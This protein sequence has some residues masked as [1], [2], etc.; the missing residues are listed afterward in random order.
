METRR[1]TWM[2][3]ARAFAILAVV[4][5]H[6]VEFAFPF[7]L[8]MWNEGTRLSWIVRLTLL[9]VGRL[10]V[11]LFLS[12]TGA[13]LLN[14]DY[15][16]EKEISRFYRQRFLRLLMCVE[17]WVLLYAFFLSWYHDLPFDFRR[18]MSSLVTT[19]QVQ[20][21]HMWYTPMILGMY[22]TIPFVARAL[23]GLSAKALLP[24][25]LVA[26]VVFSALP[27]VNLVLDVLGIV[28]REMLLDLSF[29]GG[30]Y[31]LYLIGG[32]LIHSRRALEKIPTPAVVVGVLGCFLGTAG[33]QVWRYAMGW[34]YK[35]WYDFAG[36]MA[37]GLLLFECFRRTQNSRAL[38]GISLYLSQ[39]SFA[40]YFLHFPIQCAVHAWGW[41]ELAGG[42]Y[43]QMLFLWVVPL[44]ASLALI[45]LLRPVKPIRRVLLYMN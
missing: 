34:D 33:F 16:D 8:E 27:S 18:L 19:S 9:S 13:L 11:P 17:C 28:N 3:R 29:S 15:T 39:R 22:L 7:R 6:A 37:A 38:E 14:R 5:C 40:I 10:G 21:G 30:V 4:L 45:E 1:N 25:L 41:H 2:D 44:A 24:V 36:L 26:F 20:L 23:R 43:G 42:L 32:W 12:L 31:G 35:V